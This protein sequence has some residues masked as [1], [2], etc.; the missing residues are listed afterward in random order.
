VAR[1][2]DREPGPGRPGGVGG[3]AATLGRPQG[4]YVEHAYA[5]LRRRILD[6]E[7]PA[8]TRLLEQEVTAAL[9]MSRTPIREALVR[10]EQEGLIQI[11][12]RHGI[13]V[14]PIALAD[15]REVYDIVT[16]LEAKAAE[17]LAR[18]GL[19]PDGRAA[20]ER[21]LAAMDAALAGDDRLAWAAADAEFH[22]LLVELC[23]NRRL[24]GLARTYWDQTQRARL[25]ALRLLTELRHSTAEHRALIALLVAGDA[26][27]AREAQ[28]RNRERGGRALIEVLERFRLTQL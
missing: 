23:G 14:L 16:A 20:L 8:N 22:W 12:P 15:L 17:L 6:N 9:G 26:D 28:R 13:L 27:G 11:R 25:T 4:S 3:R 7:W 21:A 10:L 1:R 18:R 24:A 19:P 5:Q 2:A